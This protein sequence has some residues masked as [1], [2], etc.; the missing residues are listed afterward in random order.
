M[1]H[2]VVKESLEIIAKY[3]GFENEDIVNKLKYIINITDTHLCGNQ[4]RMELK[5]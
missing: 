4:A 1:N 3:H 2:K 5:L